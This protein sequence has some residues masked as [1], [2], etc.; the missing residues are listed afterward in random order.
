MKKLEKPLASS[1][2]NFLLPTINGSYDVRYVRIF[3][4]KVLP[5]YV[6]SKQYTN[7]KDAVKW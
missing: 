4:C 6:L 3:I 1:S 2:V 5:K 7:K